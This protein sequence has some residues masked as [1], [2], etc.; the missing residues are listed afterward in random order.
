MIRR[1]PRSKRT[2]TR[3]PSTTRY[4]CDEQ[5]G[6]PADQRDSA[7]ACEQGLL[8]LRDLVVEVAPANLTSAFRGGAGF[9]C[10]RG[11]G[12][13]IGG[14]LVCVCHYSSPPLRKTRKALV[15][16]PGARTSRP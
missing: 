14:R 6:C 16:P 12:N 8:P 7:D 9:S 10:F 4:R 2:D 13:R 3:G 1:Q 11:L 15:T 5:E